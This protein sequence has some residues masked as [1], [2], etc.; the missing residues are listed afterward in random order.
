MALWSPPPGIHLPPLSASSRQLRQARCLRHWIARDR[1]ARRLSDPHAPSLAASRKPQ[2]NLDDVLACVSA[3]ARA[4][5]AERALVNLLARGMF[6]PSGPRVAEMGTQTDRS[7]PHLPDAHGACSPG[8]QGLLFADDS[9]GQQGLL[10]ADD[11]DSQSRD[12]TMTEFLGMAAAARR[13]VPPALVP[14]LPPEPVRVIKAP[15]L[16][17]ITRLMLCK[18]QHVRP[19]REYANAQVALIKKYVGPPN[20]QEEKDFEMHE[21]KKF[22]S[23]LKS[24]HARI[25]E[26][27][28]YRTCA[29]CD[30]EVPSAHVICSFIVC[31]ACEV[32]AKSIVEGR[33]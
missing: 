25:E 14:A 11:G 8:Q 6:S 23:Y 24:E 4:E 28:N 15:W 5:T 22:L 19:T 18:N 2:A 32:H 3:Q 27:D 33:L 21:A 13:R 30:G 16:R 17:V 10:L 31:M 20:S 12:A 26:F 7:A 9:E 1:D 29:V